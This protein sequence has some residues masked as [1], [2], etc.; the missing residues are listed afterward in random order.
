MH[1]R[2]RACRV[3]ALFALAATTAQAQVSIDGP[4]VRAVVPGQASTGAFM[5]IRSLKATALVDVSSP[6]AAAASIHRMTMIDGT[7]A[8]TPVAEVPVPAHGAVELKP[9]ALHLMLT[10]LRQPLVAGAFVPLRLRFRDADRS[11]WAVTVRAEVR[12]L[13]A[14]P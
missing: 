8:M 4:W 10:G 5:T 13:T 2:L 11:E 7:M 9:G 1:P 3:A 12:P 6:V 14:S